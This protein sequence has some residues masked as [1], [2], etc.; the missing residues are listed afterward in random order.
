MKELTEDISDGNKEVILI[1]EQR[2]G[3]AWPW[4][5]S[6]LENFGDNIEWQCDKEDSYKVKSEVL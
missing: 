2:E 5:T 6:V 4:G 3:T 1:V